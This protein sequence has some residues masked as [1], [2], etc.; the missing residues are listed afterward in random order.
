MSRQKV[1]NKEVVRSDSVFVFTEQAWEDYSHWQN[2]DP[3]VLRKVNKLLDERRRDPFKGS[4]KPGPLVGN[5][6]VFWSRRVTLADCLVYPPA[7]WIDLRRSLPLLLRLKRSRASRP[8]LPQRFNPPDA[9][10]ERRDGAETPAA[11]RD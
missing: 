11:S 7:G 3:K 2:V 9:L 8:A 10:P 5:L 1:R 4:G 6:A